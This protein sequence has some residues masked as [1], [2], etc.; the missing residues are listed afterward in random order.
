M[1]VAR[2]L[3]SPNDSE[4]RRTS[5]MTNTA[6][7]ATIELQRNSLYIMTQNGPS[8]DFEGFHWAIIC[9]D[10]KTNGTSYEWSEVE[11]EK[12]AE[13]YKRNALAVGGQFTLS[14]S[15]ISLFHINGFL[16]PSSAD[17]E[18]DEFEAQFFENVFPESFSTISDNRAHGVT[19]RTWVLRVLGAMKDCG[20][21]YREGTIADL[22]TRV[23]EVSA[24]QENLM[25][26]LGSGKSFQPLVI[27]I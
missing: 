3:H 14:P 11:G 15:T 25:K 27:D 22:A 2:S 12:L 8:A 1:S 26:G 10:A 23:E 4:K 19:S 6:P 17:L 16:P 24:E 5:V 7:E 21:L 13:S 20:F 18:Q 9:T